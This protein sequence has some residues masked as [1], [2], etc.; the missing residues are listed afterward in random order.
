MKIMICLPILANII[1]L[2]Y[3]W[4]TILR[5]KRTLRAAEYHLK[6]LTK[7]EALLNAMYTDEIQVMMPDGP[8]ARPKRKYLRFLLGMN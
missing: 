1:L 7:K 2:V 5:T 3:L 4:R 6:E 8:S